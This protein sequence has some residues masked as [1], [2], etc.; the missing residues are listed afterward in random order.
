MLAS[1]WTSTVLGVHEAFSHQYII[2]V[3]PVVL[4][5]T[6]HVLWT[7]FSLEVWLL[8]EEGRSVLWFLSGLQSVQ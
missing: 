5:D 3:F 1:L 7:V 4:H 2:F 6:I 8:V